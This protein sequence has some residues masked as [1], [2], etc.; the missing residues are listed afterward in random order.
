MISALGKSIADTPVAATAYNPCESARLAKAA[1]Y[2]AAIIQAHQARCDALYGSAFG[3][4]TQRNVIAPPAAAPPMSDGRSL[5]TG[6]QTPP[7]SDATA[8]KAKQKKILV[9]GGAAIAA[10]VVAVIII[11]KRKKKR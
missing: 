1:G 9:I 4:G 2:S 3:S 5:P 7:Q 10:V 8:D 6:Y 11:R